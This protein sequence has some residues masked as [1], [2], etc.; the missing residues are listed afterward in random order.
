MDWKFLI[1]N[2]LLYSSYFILGYF[3]IINT[4]YFIFLIIARQ[5]IKNFYKTYKY[6]NSNLIF[7]SKIIPP[8]SILLP[9]YNEEHTIINSIR[10]L[11][12]THYPQLEIIVVNDGS[13]DETL[14]VL[15]KEFNLNSIPTVFPEYITTKKIKG[16]YVSKD[17]NN[18]LVVDKENG[19]KGDAINAGINISKYP[20]FC[21]ID[22]DSILHDEG[23]LRIVLPFIENPD[24][25]VAVGGMIR[26]ANGCKFKSGS[27]F[28]LQLP[29]KILPL[30][31][32]V[33]YLRAFLFGRIGWSRLKT[34]LIISG[35]FGLFNKEAVVSAGG[36]RTDIVGEDMELI[37][38]L[39]RFFIEKKRKYQI[40]FFPNPI[41]WTEGPETLSDLRK[42]RDRWHRG[43]AES[44]FLHIKMLFNFRYGRIGLLAFPYFFFFE[45][46]GPSIEIMG[47][48]LIILAFSLG[49]INIHFLI[50]F[51]IIAVFF[52]I[53]LSIA[54]LILQEYSYNTYPNIKEVFKLLIY[55]IFENLGYRQLNS[56]FRTIALVN[57]FLGRKEWGE[58]KSKSIDRHS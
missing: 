12:L 22:A 3:L 54:S 5:E 51:I 46:F 39:H 7:Q 11:L 45:L 9:A 33:E 36:Y 14:D 35:A 58:F 6:K 42:Q 29:K 53:I 27:F 20:L 18:V 57:Y 47:Y 8:I 25:T 24:E 23:L 1:L 38:R 32:I 16:L 34:L 52:S 44:I 26:L 4:L 48:L 37:V 13:T 15:K 40:L 31:Q 21:T 49:I 43:L 30:F 41:C 56:F 17:F 50:I 10:S 28:K 2:L 19:G 55:S